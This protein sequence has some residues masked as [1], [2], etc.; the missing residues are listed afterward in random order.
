[1]LDSNASPHDGC[2]RLLLTKPAKEKSASMNWKLEGNY[3]TNKDRKTMAADGRPDL[4]TIG[5]ITLT[6]KKREIDD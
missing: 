2:T 6:W 4:G 5:T 1:M 3:W